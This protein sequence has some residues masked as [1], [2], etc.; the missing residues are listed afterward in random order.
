MKEL[1]RLDGLTDKQM[2]E[3]WA[4][5]NRWGWPA[6]LPNPEERKKYEGGGNPRRDALMSA[7]VDRIGLK[8]CLRECNIDTMTD[9]EFDA[10]WRRPERKVA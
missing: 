10:F 4:T 3:W 6:D 5:L 2:A 1:D 8:A 7:I 9:D